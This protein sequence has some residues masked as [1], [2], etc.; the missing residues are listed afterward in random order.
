MNI[1]NLTEIFGNGNPNRKEITNRQYA[2]R[3]SKLAERFE[4][5]TGEFLNDPPPIYEYLQG[6]P[7]NTQS[8][9]VSSI[10]EY[11]NSTNADPKLVAEYKNRKSVIADAIAEN[12]SKNSFSPSQQENFVSGEEFNDY[13]N[14]VSEHFKGLDPIVHKG[15]YEELRNVRLLLHLYK[16]YP[17]RNEYANL[18]FITLREYKKFKTNEMLNYIIIRSGKNPLLSVGKY[19]TDKTYGLKQTEITDPITKKLVKDHLTTRGYNYLFT[20]TKDPSKVWENHNLATILTKWSLHFINKRISSTMIYKIVINELGLEYKKLLDEGKITEAS[21]L[22]AILNEHARI[23]GH[24]DT[25][26]LQ[27]YVKKSTEDPKME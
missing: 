6:R 2:L 19:K 13:V 21:K 3:L 7:A 5:D 1:D 15:Y 27:I 14:K 23:R 8:N 20:L 12:Y 26:Q 25:T 24:Q 4:D 10:V 16:N 11:L 9:V 22:K 17:S 18:K